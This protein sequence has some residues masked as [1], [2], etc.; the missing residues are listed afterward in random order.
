MFNIMIFH[1]HAPEYLCCQSLYAILC[2]SILPV[3]AIWL[4]IK[5]FVFVCENFNLNNNLIRGATNLNFL[6]PLFQV[7]ILVIKIVLFIM[8]FLTGTICQSK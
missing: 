2:C 4:S 5:L 6:V 3:M 8:L 1:G 7:E